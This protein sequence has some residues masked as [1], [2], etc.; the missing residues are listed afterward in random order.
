[1]QE[2]KSDNKLD[3]V[4]PCQL[5][6]LLA[7]QLHLYRFLPLYSMSVLNLLNRRRLLEASSQNNQTAIRLYARTSKP[8]SKLGRKP[9]N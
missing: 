1:M 2:L 3:I 6:V 7:V 5:L 4:K 8:R 9:L